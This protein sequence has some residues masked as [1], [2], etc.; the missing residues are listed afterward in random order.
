M[1]VETPLGPDDRARTSEAAVP[2]DGQPSLAEAKGRDA[3]AAPL[4]RVSGLRK[5]YAVDGD[6]SVVA[7]DRVDF[8]VADGEFVSLVGPSGCG[9]STLLQILAGILAP[10][11]GEIMLAGRAVRGPRRD[12]GVVFQEATLLPWL[13]VIDN[14]LLPAVVHKLDRT[15]FRARAEELLVLVKLQGLENRYPYELS[16][17]MQQRVSIARALLNDPAMILMDEPFGALDAM[18]REQMNLELLGIWARAKK[19]I[20]LITHSIQEA[21]LL[22]DRVV[23]LSARPG[24]VIDIIPIE[25]PRPRSFQMLSSPEFGAAALRIRELLTAQGG[26]TE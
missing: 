6:E 3:L 21:V 1:V 5:E 14:V 7:I 19:T 8:D 11:R 13:T 18:T 26:L 2:S 24:S 10:S 15:K 12:V 16:G 22:S 9:K 4:I 25:L 17:G 23:V 20:V